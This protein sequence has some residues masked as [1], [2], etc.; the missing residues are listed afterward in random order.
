MIMRN[1][2]GRF[3]I[4]K[5]GATRQQDQVVFADAAPGAVSLCPRNVL[6]NEGNICDYNIALAPYDHAAIVQATF[7]DGT[8]KLWSDNLITKKQ[9]ILQVGV[10][11]GTLVQLLGWDRLPTQ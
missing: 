10:G 3:Q 8:N 11:S 4:V 5:V 6:G 2:N 9:F 7:A 1:S